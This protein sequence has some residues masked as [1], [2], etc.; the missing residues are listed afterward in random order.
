MLFRS[1]PLGNRVEQERVREL[2][3]FAVLEAVE[4]RRWEA[5]P[6]RVGLLAGLRGWRRRRVGVGVGVERL[7]LEV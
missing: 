6:L 4:E 3:R 2:H 1:R 7:E 5:L